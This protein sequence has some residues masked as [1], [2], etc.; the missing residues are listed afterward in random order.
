MIPV[1]L[2]VV[3]LIA[4]FNGGPRCLQVSV[5]GIKK[6]IYSYFRPLYLF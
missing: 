1:V 5:M 3:M 4:R 2:G 6:L